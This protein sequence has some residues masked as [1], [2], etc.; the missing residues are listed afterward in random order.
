[1]IL[2]DSNTRTREF[3]SLLGTGLFISCLSYKAPNVIMVVSVKDAEGSGAH[4][5][6]VATIFTDV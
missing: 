6:K 3:E 4:L 5:F 1:M 2:G